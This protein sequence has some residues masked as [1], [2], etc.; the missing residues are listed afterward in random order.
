MRAAR[1]T[2]GGNL[3]AGLA[4]LLVALPA[5]TR[6]GD[7]SSAVDEVG[8]AA[9][10]PWLLR[11][12]LRDVKAELRALYPAGGSGLVWFENGRPVPAL[13]ASL[14]AIG[15][16]AA[17][18]LDP[19]DFDSGRLI[20]AA[21]AA[22]AGGAT[23]RERGLLDVALSVEWMRYLSAVHGGRVAAPRAGRGRDLPPRTL[24]LPRLVRE[25]RAAGN[26]AAVVAAV[27]PRHLGYVR[28][29]S[30]L[31]RHRALAAAPP[32][33]EVPVPVA[34]VTPDQI[35]IG[36]PAVRA[37]LLALGDLAADVPPPASP[38]HYDPGLA[39][40]VKRFQER[41]ALVD[42]G[43]LGKKTVA[44][45]NVPPS[46]RLRQVELALERWRWLPDPGRRV[47]VVEIPRAELWAIDMERGATDLGMRT[48]V[49]ES[50]S[51]ATP[52]LAAS[53]SM[54]VFRPYWVPPP[55]I[56]K[57]EILP[58]ARVDPAWLAKH[59]MEIVATPEEDAETFEPTEDVL[60]RVAKGE[61]TLR[62]RPGP[63]SDLGAV[64][65]VVPDAQC[66][67]LHGTPYGRLFE[68]PQRDRS[69]GCIRLQNPDALARWV[70][71]GE[72]GWD[73]ARIAAAAAGERS[74]TVKLRE[75]VQ[76]VFVY[77]TAAVDPDGTEHFVDDIYRLDAKLERELARPG[78]DRRE[79]R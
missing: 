79:A 36:I 59:G 54:V 24:D 49:G 28:L 2:G 31:A 50:R 16:G 3:L 7:A 78:S 23:D 25:T 46:R 4:A 47:V 17:L 37:R 44:A 39:A 27:E 77:G 61:L 22:A 76:V 68:L 43:V 38:D 71:G 51:H 19:A 45:M 67:A 65:F 6:A 21:R 74:T 30:A 57:E 42:D 60:S 58:K 29:K 72:P 15:D 34:K 75:P 20:E 5:V 11:A 69:H 40:A 26:P 63:R 33:P 9:R 66:I 55:G 12:D 32:L 41:H 73:A 52:M 53:I 70:L 14:K 64:K 62:Q 18:G 8:G 35:W 48:V 10:H 1:S 56:L 13:E